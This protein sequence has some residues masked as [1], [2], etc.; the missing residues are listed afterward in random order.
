MMK[1]GGT[2]MK[3][4]WLAASSFERMHELVSAINI[5]SIHAKLRLAEKADPRPGEELQAARSRLK[6]FLAEFEDVLR[7]ADRGGGG[8]LVGTDPR[9]GEMAMRFAAAHRRLPQT[10]ELYRFPP[11]H[12][13]G[14]IDSE[15]AKDLPLLIESLR[16]LRSLLEQ[17]SQADVVGILGDV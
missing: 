9:L 13:S 6:K 8:A 14:L 10:S 11:E 17:S 12:L 2:V 16:D 7:E 1:K 3:A 4:D 15:S 5:L